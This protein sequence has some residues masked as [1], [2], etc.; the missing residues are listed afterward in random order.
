M[1]SHIETANADG[2]IYVESNETLNLKEMYDVMD[3][4]IS[5]YD[6]ETTKEEAIRGIINLW[7]DE[8]QGISTG[9]VMPSLRTEQT[10]NSEDVV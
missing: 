3:A 7:M 8:L 9:D 5:A 1:R 10:L 4:I 6:H 2:C